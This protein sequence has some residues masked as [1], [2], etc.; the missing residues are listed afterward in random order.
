M[1]RIRYG[2]RSA[3][4]LRSREIE[5]TSVGAWATTLTAHYETDAELISAVLPPPLEPPDEPLVRVTIATVDLGGG[6]PPFGAGTLA[7]RARHE[8]TAGDSPLVMPMPTKHAVIG[9]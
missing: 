2:A 1:A 5:A 9:R 8:G 4:E 3:E 7:V 6:R